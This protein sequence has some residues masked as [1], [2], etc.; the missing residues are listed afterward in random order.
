MPGRAGLAP[1]DGNQVVEG[2]VKKARSG[3][4]QRAVHKI[5]DQK[6]IFVMLPPLPTNHPAF[7]LAKATAQKPLTL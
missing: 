3:N 5:K 4:P 7:G 2:R 1:S 6:L